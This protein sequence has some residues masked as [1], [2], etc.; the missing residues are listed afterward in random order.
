MQ[1]F[2]PLKS[3]YSPEVVE[4]MLLNGYTLIYHDTELDSLSFRRDNV[5]VMFWQDKIERRIISPD[6]T[7]VTR[8]LKSFKGFDG[9][10][11]FHLMLILHLIGAVNLKDVK[12]EVKRE[13]AAEGV[14][15]FTQLVNH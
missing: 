13:M 7:Q 1:A 4:Y 2:A 6:K 12:E 8:H 15:C 5:G 14:A 11:V 9:K 10:D 3:A